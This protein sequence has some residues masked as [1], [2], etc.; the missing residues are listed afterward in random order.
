MCHPAID[1]ISNGSF[2]STFN[3][4]FPIL[5]T[6]LPST[7]HTSSYTFTSLLRQDWWKLSIMTVSTLS[8]THISSKFHCN[9]LLPPPLLVTVLATFTSGF[10]IAET[11]EHS[12]VLTDCSYS[13]W[14]SKCSL[15]PFSTL[16]FRERV[17]H[18]FWYSSSLWG[19]ISDASISFI[20][21]S[22]LSIA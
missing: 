6:N 19:G 10:L 17:W 4:S 21:F 5:K 3:P 18:H 11:N 16:S 14:N 20:G 9:L 2:L 13:V 7:S 15:R 22:F 8:L 1:N 12:S